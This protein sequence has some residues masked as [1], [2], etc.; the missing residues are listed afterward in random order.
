MGLMRDVLTA[1][2]APS[3]AAAVKPLAD[4]V[5]AIEDAI[6]ALQV[7]AD[8]AQRL[9]A[10]EARPVVDPGVTDAL[11]A[12]LAALAG[13]TAE[14][15][16]RPV[17]DPQINVAIDDA[18]NEIRNQIAA[19]EAVPTLTEQQAADLGAVRGMIA[20]LEAMRAELQATAQ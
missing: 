6:G 19:L 3:V 11:S 5:K 18:L 12:A 9:D 2:V 8:L 15:E 1:L 10:L 7:P 20:D 16:A 13:R 17:Y 14:L 4:R